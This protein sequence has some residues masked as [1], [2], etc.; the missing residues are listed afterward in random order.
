[1]KYVACSFKTIFLRVALY[2]CY[3]FKSFVILMGISIH[4]INSHVQVHQKQYF[5]IM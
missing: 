3:N 1:M 4:F 5:I 2:V